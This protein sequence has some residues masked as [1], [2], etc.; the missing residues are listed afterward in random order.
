MARRG[1]RCRSISNLE[2]L[3]LI[4]REI[5]R[6]KIEQEALKKES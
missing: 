6:L 1:S 5:V 3:D 2:E 4:D